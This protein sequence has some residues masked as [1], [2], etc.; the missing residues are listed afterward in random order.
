MARLTRPVPTGAAFHAP[1]EAQP[2]VDVA[3]GGEPFDEAFWRLATVARRTALRIVHDWAEAED[4]AAETLAR[5]DARWRRLRPP[6]DGW[7][8]TVAMRLALDRQRKAW[9][10]QPLEEARVPVDGTRWGEI[11]DRIDLGR[12][13]RKLSRRQRQAVALR[14]LAD[15]SE[16]QASQAMGVSVT[17]LRTH[18]QRALA[19]LR[20]DLDPPDDRPT[21]SG[22]EP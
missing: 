11:D 15:L 9:R 22:E 18:C 3:G 12:L 2:G 1:T 7:I 16:E 5:A 4:I 13:L 6:V 17:T 19:T 21:T 14:Y 20:R 10:N 8:V